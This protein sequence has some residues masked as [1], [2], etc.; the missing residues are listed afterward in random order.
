MLKLLYLAAAFNSTQKTVFQEVTIQATAQIQTTNMKESKLLEYIGRMDPRDRDRFRSFVQ[1]PY[2][3]QHEKTIQL[4]DLVLKGLDNTST[5]SGYP[6]SLERKAVHKQLFPGEPYDEQQLFNVMSYLKKL[7]HRF[8]AY[9]KFGEEELEESLLTLE[10]AFSKNQFDLL[11]NRS[12]QIEKRLEKYAF[13]DSRFLLASYRYYNTL[14][15]YS[16]HYEDR[17]KGEHLQHMLN[18]LDR[19]YLLEKLKHAC[20]LTANNINVNTNF[21]LSFF[22]ALLDYYR[23]NRDKY[24]HDRGIALYYAI[25]MSLKEADQPSHYQQLK[26]LLME[27]RQHFSIAQQR[28]L[29]ISANNYCIS[30]INQGDTSY[31]TE[32]FVLYQ[33]GLETGLILDNDLLTEWNFKNITALGCLLKEYEWTEQFVQNYRDKLP[34]HRRENAYNYNLAHL[35]Y[36]KRL[37]KEAQRV[38]LLVQFSDVKY[39]LSANSLLLRIYYESGDTEALL[40]LIDTFRIYIIRNRKMTV[41]QKRGF[42]NFLRF[43]K[44]LALLKHHAEAY[45]RRGLEEKLAALYE[46]LVQTPNVANRLWLEEECRPANVA[47]PVATPIVGAPARV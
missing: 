11:K 4:L 29:F 21:D 26:Q 16:S 38:L 27:E 43:S 14:G 35:Y 24:A 5:S 2:F 37:Y 15:Y 9:E 25:Y 20:H 30:R 8:L 45:S 22:E 13:Q 23:Q 33:L 44:K 1:S 36:S 28:D 10:A 17:T 6:T 12:K 32:L 19:Y 41:E 34:L 18:Y 7:H 42:T 47:A 39:H 3:N 31:Q 40:S 46:K